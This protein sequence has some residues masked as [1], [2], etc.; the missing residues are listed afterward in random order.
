MRASASASLSMVRRAATVVLPA[1]AAAALIAAPAQ[2]QESYLR[3]T[4]YHGGST[5]QWFLTCGPDGGVHPEPGAA[6]DR[7][8][9]LGGDLDRIRFRPGVACPRIFDPVH[10]EIRGDYLGEP[11]DFTD[12]YPNPCFVERLA[13]PIVPAV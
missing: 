10:V 13:A 5:A 8:E 9:E 11:V 6:C 2:A 7:L 4:T 12:D 3:I 1:L